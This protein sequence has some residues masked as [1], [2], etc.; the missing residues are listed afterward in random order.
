MKQLTQ[1]EKTK[2]L[3]NLDRLHQF[4]P[5]VKDRYATLS[6]LFYFINLIVPPIFI[7]A[8]YGI[9]LFLDQKLADCDNGTTSAC[10]RPPARVPPAT[11]VGSRPGTSLYTRKTEVELNKVPRTELLRGVD[12]KFGLLFKLLRW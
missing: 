1:E 8:Y 6:M 10:T 12:R 9:G 2:F 3:G 7:L 4:L 5:S 11:Q